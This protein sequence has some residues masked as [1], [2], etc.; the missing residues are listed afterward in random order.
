MPAAMW[1]ALV[2]SEPAEERQFP[3]WLSAP[4]PYRQIAPSEPWRQ[5]CCSCL[6]ASLQASAA[7]MASEPQARAAAPS[8]P[9]HQ[10]SSQ[11]ASGQRSEAERGHP[12]T[13]QLA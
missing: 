11:A 12:A 8:L 6:P 9:E 4:F 2:A 10:A 3:P 13:E 1:R 7:E 5:T